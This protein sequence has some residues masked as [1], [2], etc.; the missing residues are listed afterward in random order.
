MS[1]GYYTINRPYSYNDRLTFKEG[2]PNR[3]LAK[4][5]NK[6]ENIV[7][8]T[9]DTFVK[10]E[11]VDE[12]KKKTHKTAI[13]VGS[14]VFVISG[15][16]ALLNPKFSNKLFNK[17]KVAAQKAGNKAEA[18]KGFKGKLYRGTQKALDNTAQ[19]LQFTNTINNAKDKG[20][21][22]L[23][24]EEKTFKSVKNDGVRNALVNVDKGVRKVLTKPYSGITNFF[25]SISKGTVFKQCRSANNSITSLEDLVK[26]YKDKLPIDAQRNL[27]VKL[28]EFQS[29][30]EYF[31]KSQ[32]EGRLKNQEQAMSNLESDFVKK[33][34]EYVQGFKNNPSGKGKHFK[35][36]MSFWAEDILMPE[37]NRLEA[38]GQKVINTLVGDGKSQKGAFNEIF[39][40]I[41]PHVSKEE[42]AVLEN[43]I[44]KTSKSL[45][46]A[47]KSECVE[48][49]DKKRDLIL[50]SA[51]TD[52]ATA[53]AGIVMSGVAIGTADTKDE[54][55]SRA[56]TVAAPAV[57]GLGTSMALTAMLFSGVKGMIYGSLASL[58]LSVVGSGVDKYLIPKS[59]AQL[60]K[61]EQT[62]QAQ[63]VSNA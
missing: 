43:K 61:N 28:K 45:S 48:Y 22:W 39:D 52:V 53:A 44:A 9:V 56:V 27:D 29:V 50:G 34:H 14:S 33:Y 62:K 13:L 30:K 10:T 16:V 7:N 32:V 15:L 1:F 18:D 58:G 41:S 17:M 37:R 25:D 20:F 23:C 26:L 51:P 57:L 21:K 11:N 6:V 59:P 47:N 35:D 46:K 40:I 31:A 42:A 5:I 24:T 8:N 55:I 3:I 12:E 19:F 38:E 4:P 63:E 2:D 36:N 54:R 49:F 60:A